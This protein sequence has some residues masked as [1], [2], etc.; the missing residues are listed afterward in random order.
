[1][2]SV[3][4][5]RALIELIEPHYSRTSSNGN[6]PPYS[7]EMMLRIHLQQQWYSLDDPAMEDALFEVVTMH[8]FAGI[9]MISDQIPGETTI[10]AFR[11]L[12]LEK[13]DLGRQ[14]FEVVKAPTSRPTAWPSSKAR[15]L[16]PP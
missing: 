10:L 2:E 5:W 12:L 11:H 4:P 13:H 1:M 7:L 14:I 3:V 16:M 15:S 6:R 8:R 9:A